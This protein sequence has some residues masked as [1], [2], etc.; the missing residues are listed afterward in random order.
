MYGEHEPYPQQ[1]RCHWARQRGSAL[2]EF[3]V[4]VPLFVT[5]VY[6]SLYLSDLGRFRLKAQE[7]ARYGAWAFTQRPLSGYRHD[8][9][10]RASQYHTE[11]FDEARTQV[12]QEVA[13]IYDD[14]D[15]ANDRWLPGASAQTMSAALMPPATSDF[16]NQSVSLTP[17]WA[18]ASLAEPLSTLWMVLQ[19]LQVGGSVNEFVTG[20]FKRLGFNQKGQITAQAHV[21]L[22]PPVTLRAQREALAMARVG[23]LRGA[24]LSRL[25]SP[26]MLKIKDRSGR[27]IDTTLI[28]DSWKV[29][30]GWS[31]F[32]GGKFDNGAK[33]RQYANVVQHVSDKAIE[34]LPFG[35]LLNIFFGSKFPK[36]L[37]EAAALFGKP[38]DVAGQ[39]VFSRPYIA[40]REA[41]DNRRIG[42]GCRPQP[43]QTNIF[44]DTDSEKHSAQAQESGAVHCFETGPLYANPEAGAQDASK[45][46]ELLN[47]RGPYFMGCDKKETRG[48]WE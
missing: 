3:A 43:G 28:A 4:V 42:K 19:F 32:P 7:I 14:L 21:A 26:V 47:K 5:L 29:T 10:G 41:V 36:I 17:E 11:M 34:A 13:E 1:G 20:P 33:E 44:S 45:Y 24:D 40:D 38:P 12:T 15:G 37:Q 8:D 6:G 30:D 2:T 9:L 39:R 16:K 31:T 35:S 18:N 25:S 46:L 22:N 27:A 48:C 23:G